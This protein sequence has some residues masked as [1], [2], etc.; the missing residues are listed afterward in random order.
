VAA[1]VVTG[2]LLQPNALRNKLQFRRR[3]S[4]ARASLWAR[5]YCHESV[6]VVSM[7][8]SQTRIDTPRLLRRDSAPQRLDSV[9]VLSI[10][11]EFYDDLLSGPNITATTTAHYSWHRAKRVILLTSAVVLRREEAS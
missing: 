6:S 11:Q 10:D 7:L 3:G 5:G 9:E 1:Y 2:S 8:F 4:M